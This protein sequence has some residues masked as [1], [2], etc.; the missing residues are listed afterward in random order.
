MTRRYLEAMKY[1]HLTIAAT[2]I[3]RDGQAKLHGVIV[4]SG[5]NTT[6]DIFNG[7][8]V[9]S[10]AVGVVNCN[11]GGTYDYFGIPLASG[12]TIRLNDPA[13]VTVIYE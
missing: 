5:S 6:L 8:N 13:D 12:L 11:T 10:P 7:P 9:S 2:A 4:N 3:A 1:A